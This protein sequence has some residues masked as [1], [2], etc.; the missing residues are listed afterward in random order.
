MVLEHQPVPLRLDG[1]RQLRVHSSP[2]SS[3]RYPKPEKAR[4]TVLYIGGDHECRIVLARI[5]RRLEGVQLVATDSWR[6]G[7]ALASSLSPH[8]IVLDTQVTDCATYDLLVDFVHSGRTVVSPLA[9]L[10]GTAN[11]RTR[12]MHGG[13]TAC[14]TKP[15]NIAEVERMMTVLLDRCSAR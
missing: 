2:R 6:E 8:L 1:G 14:L 15:L 3:R 11:E 4:R 7:R 12:F 5:G 10:S 9:V 13:A